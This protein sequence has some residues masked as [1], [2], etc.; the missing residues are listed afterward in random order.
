MILLLLGRW[1][2]A[3]QDEGACGEIGAAA[4]DSKLS[5]LADVLGGCERLAGTPLPFPYV[6]MI[7]RTVYLY[8]ILLPFGLYR[9]IGPMTPVISV[10]IAYTFLAFEALARELEEP[11]GTDPNDLPLDAMSSMIEE[12]LFEMAGVEASGNARETQG[13]RL[14]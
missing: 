14:S 11:F 12:T 4:L 1:V 7:H 8:C 3:R 9:D 13:Y 2:R 10:L 5:G 6:I